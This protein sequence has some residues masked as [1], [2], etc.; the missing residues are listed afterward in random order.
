[1]NSPG[2]RIVLTCSIAG[3]IALSTAASASAVIRYAAPG[4]TADPSGCV[5]AAATDV[6]PTPCSIA[7][8]ATG[9]GVLAADEVV[10]APG[11]Y[12]DT[13]GDLGGGGSVNPVVTK[14]GGAPGKPRPVIVLD[15]PGSFVFQI[16]GAD[17]LSRVELVS[18]ARDTLIYAQGGTTEG[19]IA[20]S[21]A[22]GMS[23]TCN[24]Q[25]LAMLRNSVCFAMSAGD[26]AVGADGSGINSVILR[27]VTAVSR[28]SG[29]TAIAYSCT[30][31]TMGVAVANTVARAPLGTDVKAS[32]DGGCN[33][34]ITLN[35]SNF[36]TTDD[37][38][39]TA[40]VTA[41]GSGTNETT[42]P[43][44]AA[45]GY[46]QLPAS[47]GTIDQGLSD[48][49]GNGPADI[50]G[51]TR[52]LDGKPDIGAD[53]LGHPTSTTLACAPA[54]LVLGSGSANCHLEVT[55]I[56]ADPGGPTGS[57]SF[58]S[59]GPGTF[60]G[61]GVCTLISIGIGSQA[62]E[63]DITYTPS[64]VGSGT[65]EITGVYAIG[66]F[67][68]GSQGSASV[69]VTLPPPPP[70]PPAPAQ[71][72]APETAGKKCKKGR[73]LVKRKGKRKCIKRKQ[74]R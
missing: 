45:D 60:G 63:C 43:V 56:S 38:G 41:P 69:G 5:I 13:A 71:P 55:D 68:E 49:A 58:S 57:V 51:Q 59:S 66:T 29:G 64:A 70:A 9:A 32:E 25:G 22:A 24:I 26:R 35:N 10:I 47:A 46:H 36:S 12:S 11:N 7:T 30:S 65:H 18:A 34:S 31:G 15:S 53:E 6:S 16:G 28:G 37:D 4:G 42:A 8:A 67:H 73:K 54:S 40:P 74:K 72:G 19:V 61:G 39:G 20:S 27:N 2:R 3:A 52:N 44:F 50:D 23:P 48:F 21:T 33:T 17:V 1:M 62:A 14:I